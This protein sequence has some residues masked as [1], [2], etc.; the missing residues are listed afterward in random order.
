MWGFINS[1]KFS[2]GHEAAELGRAEIGDS[3]WFGYWECDRGVCKFLGITLLK[4]SYAKQASTTG[5]CGGF[6]YVVAEPKCCIRTVE[7]S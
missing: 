3:L 4:P 2:C 6:L 7:F 1:Q 5:G